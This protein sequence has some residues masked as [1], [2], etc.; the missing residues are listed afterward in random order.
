MSKD[1]NIGDISKNNKILTN[2]L[3]IIIAFITVIISIQ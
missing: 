2:V 3:I 1:N